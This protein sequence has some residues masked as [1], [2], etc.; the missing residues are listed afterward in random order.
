RHTRF[1]RDWSS[2]CALP[3]FEV[4]ALDK[5][6]TL[7][8][9]KPMVTDVVPLNGYTREQLLSLG[10]ALSSRSDHPVS[11]A[12]ADYARDSVGADAVSEIGRASC[13]ERDG[14]QV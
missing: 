4:L 3:I 7:T 8:L 1:S 6:G 11:M 2:E 13:R 5:T 12:I 14:V 9:G 10:G